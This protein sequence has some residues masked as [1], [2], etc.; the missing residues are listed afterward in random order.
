MAIY[1]KYILG[2]SITISRKLYNSLKKEHKELLKEELYKN[3]ID[4][5]VL[6]EGKRKY[7]IRRKQNGCKNT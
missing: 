6:I 2:E 7:T 4:R 1:Q 3:G 5:I